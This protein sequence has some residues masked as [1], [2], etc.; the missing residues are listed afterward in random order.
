MA[1]SQ[2]PT[3]KQALLLTVGGIFFAFFSCVGALV[4]IGGNGA[5]NVLTELGFAG[6]ALGLLVTIVGIVLLLW[7]AFRP[8]F[9]KQQPPPTEPTVQVNEPRTTGVNESAPV[10]PL[11]R[12][13]PES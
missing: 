11:T 1:P 5:G 7:I 6:F 9:R 4:N 3:L 8:F 2:K 13:D 12:R 10:D